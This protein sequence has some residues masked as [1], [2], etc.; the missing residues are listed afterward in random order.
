MLTFSNASLSSPSESYGR[1]ACRIWD[2]VARSRWM[3]VFVLSILGSVFC[4]PSRT[5][6]QNP[7]GVIVDN[8]AVSVKDATRIYTGT[9]CRSAAAGSYVTNSLYSCGSGADT[10]RW[11]FTPPAAGEY[12]VYVWWTS[13]VTRSTS[14]PITVSDNTGPHVKTFNERVNGGKW[15]LHGR[16]TFATNTTRYVEVSDANGQAA[17][18]AVRLAPVSSAASTLTLNSTNASSVFLKVYPSDTGGSGDGTAP[19]VR[20]F[21]SNTRVWLSA[22][23]RNGNGYFVKWQKNAQDYDLASTTSV[24]MDGDHTLT[25]IYGAA[26][27]TGITVLPGTDSVRTAVAS[28]PAGSTFCIKSGIHRF[29]TSVVARANDKFIGE[30]GAIISGSKILSAFVWDGS[31][32][33]ATGQ[34]QQEPTF[35]VT[36]GGYAMCTTSAPGCVYPEKVFRD[37]QDLIQVTRLTDLA[38][39]TFY[40]SYVNDKIYLFDDPTGHNLEA[41]TGTG[42]I[43]GYT[44][45]GQGGV[46][47]KYLQF[48][49][50]GGGDVSG[51]D[52]NAIK[53][54]EGWRVENNEFRLISSA[55]IAN[56]G[57]GVVRNNYIHHNG[58]YG[59]IGEGTIEGNVIS[60]NNTDGFDPNND[61]GGSKFHGTRG[62]SVR[63]N[64]VAN[65]VG[66]GFWTDFDNI[67]TVYE[68]NIAENN[69][70]MGIFHEVSCAAS[71]KYNIARGNNADKAGRSLWHGGQI[72]LRSSKDVQIF[73]NEVIAAGPGTHGISLRGGDSP[74]T[75]PNCGSLELRNVSVRD[76]VV[77]LDSTDLHGIVGGGVGHGAANSLSFTNNIYYLQSLSGV[78]FWYDAAT[79]SMTKEQWKAANQDVGG[80]FLQY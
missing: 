77:R 2:P 1:F 46:T 19:T 78:Y 31:Y 9:W 54:V 55:A 36:N 62:L 45:A 52:H 65:N 44:N 25:A 67:N 5:L 50:F 7:T 38:T 16:Y 66:R 20:T 26:S 73:G 61:A 49:K 30:P 8:A 22:P 80:A 57:S 37:G 74:L 56:F 12:D 63:G 71:I 69:S 70:E 58:K 6:A 11:T 75:G 13:H 59:I 79:S 34:N 64:V 60:Y 47:V 42:G 29:T 40:F 14:V 28:A 10:Y 72:F 15:V 23:L 43:I 27:C 48:E 4:G 41:T 24:A 3:G 68:N 21:G 32:W 53:P 39:G 76:N 17:A 35:P 18:D 51:S 33:V